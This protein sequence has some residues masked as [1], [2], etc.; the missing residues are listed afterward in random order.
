MRIFAIILNVT[1]FV[2]VIL[3]VVEYG[4][5]ALLDEE[6]IGFFVTLSFVVPIIS[7]IT[8]LGTFKRSFIEGQIDALKKSKEG[9]ESQ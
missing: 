2:M 4:F 7:I 1:L 9:D 8:L 5:S 6:K 3:C